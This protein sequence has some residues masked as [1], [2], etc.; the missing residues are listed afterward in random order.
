MSERLI[1]IGYM[2]TATTYLQN[3]VFSDET[4]GFGLPGGDQSRATFC[5]AIILN[6]GFTFDADAAR[7]RLQN[8]DKPVH[9][10]GLL[11]VWSE[12]SL[13]GDPNAGRYDAFVNAERLRET[14]PNSKIFVTIRE[15]KALARS[16][17]AECLH[18]GGTIRTKGY[19]GTGSESLSMT[20]KLRHEYLQYDR[21]VQHYVNSFGAENV[22]V[23]PQEL[24]RSSPVYY[25]DKLSDFLDLD[26]LTN[27]ASTEIHGSLS[28]R[29]LYVGRI[30]NHLFT[31]DPLS[32][33]GNPWQRKVFD[34][35]LRRLDRL[36]PK[37]LD[38][39]AERNLKNYVNIRY[40]GAFA[41]SNAKLAALTGLDLA[42]LGYEL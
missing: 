6:D 12:E 37:A 4:T 33:G 31:P 24:L 30:L 9:A 22:L 14:L 34:G 26:P 27:L 21:L 28:A 29:G 40:Q 42:E 38:F 16:H 1:H 11:P 25:F 5:D 10:R 39:G 19:F 32:F 3:S 17:Y 15:Q 35:I 8:L 20:P 36:V 41:A 2:K 23:L 7:Q 13:T 18:S